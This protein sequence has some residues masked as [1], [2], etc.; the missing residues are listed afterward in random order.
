MT[1]SSTRTEVID[2]ETSRIV[3]SFLECNLSI[4][5]EITLIGNYYDWKVLAQLLAQLG[6]PVR[7]F[8]ERVHICDVV[9]DQGTYSMSNKFH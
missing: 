1:C 8:L 3:L 4:G 6:H 2:T 7:H 9:Y 5:L